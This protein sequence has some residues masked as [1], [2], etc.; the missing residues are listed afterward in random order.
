MKKLKVSCTR[1][2]GDKVEQSELEG[3]EEDIE[4]EKTGIILCPFGGKKW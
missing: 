4:V 2:V 1:I 3:I